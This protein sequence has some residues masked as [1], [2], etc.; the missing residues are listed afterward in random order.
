MRTSFWIYLGAVL[1]TIVIGLFFY[2]NGSKRPTDNGYVPDK[3]RGRETKVPVRIRRDPANVTVDSRL[4]NAG[5][6]L[7][8]RLLKA[9]AA[10]QPRRNVLLAPPVLLQS[11]AVLLPG[12]GKD[13]RGRV[14]GAMGV[15]DMSADDLGIA[16]AALLEL[17]HRPDQNTGLTLGYGVWAPA[18]CT[19]AD[20]YADGVSEA[21][22]AE[23]GVLDPAKVNAWAQLQS[24]GRVSTLLPGTASGVVVGSLATLNAAWQDLFSAK[25]TGPGPFVLADGTRT[26]VTMLTRV[27]SYPYCENSQF[28]A[29]AL[30]YSTGR[31]ELYLILPAANIPLS[32]FVAAMTLDNWNSWMPSFSPHN[33]TLAVPRFHLSSAENYASALGVAGDADF[34][35]MLAGGTPALAQVRH[36]AQ[37]EAFE[38]GTA[39]GAAIDRSKLPAKVALP[40]PGPSVTMTCTRPFLLAVRERTSG[41]L[42]FLGN[43]QDPR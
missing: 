38:A 25:D 18:G 14:L 8:F 23:T 20:G 11:L 17:L 5:N 9:Q 32:T 30:P 27:G 37:L 26:K 12:A 13:T 21:F 16:N 36:A 15:R 3:P 43:V 35:D 19:F 22:G 28:Q 34:H 24:V 39:T 6:R 2:M 1:V 33:V 29:V 31:L 10:A 7:G 4:V 42:F 41:A 40:D